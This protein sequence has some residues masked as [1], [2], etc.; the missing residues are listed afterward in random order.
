MIL[1]REG[2]RH[3][4]HSG[5]ILSSPL[6]LLRPSLPG[7]AAPRCPRS[8]EEVE[9]VGAGGGRGMSLPAANIWSIPR[10][11][12]LETEGAS[13]NRAVQAWWFKKKKKDR[14]YLFP[15]LGVHG[16]EMSRDRHD[17]NSSRL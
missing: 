4:R 7:P 10:R 6:G 3:A 11:V 12:H 5:A 1:L 15:K 9:S 13:R 2:R 14:Y 16:T 8:T 17:R